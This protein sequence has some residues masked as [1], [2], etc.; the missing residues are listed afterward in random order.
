MAEYGGAIGFVGLVEYYPS[1]ALGTNQS[2]TSETRVSRETYDAKD[3]K[4]SGRYTETHKA[5]EIS[6]KCRR[7][8]SKEEYKRTSTVKYT[9]KL[10]GL[11]TEYHTEFKV[12]KLVYPSAAK[13]SSNK[14]KYCY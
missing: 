14:R 9:D 2:E 1:E 3:Y 7:I 6:N 12:K 8:G 11:T 4:Y 5:V 13:S 10:Q